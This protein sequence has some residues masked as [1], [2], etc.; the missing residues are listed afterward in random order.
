[1]E[2]RRVGNMRQRTELRIT[3]V[4]VMLELKVT[5]ECLH[6]QENDDA[7]GDTKRIDN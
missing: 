6:Y 5:V 1:M 2:V 7:A 3:R 4:V